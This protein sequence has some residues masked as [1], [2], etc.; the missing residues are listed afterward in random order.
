[1]PIDQRVLYIVE[2]DSACFVGETE[3]RLA[4]GSVRSFA[5][6]VLDFE[7]GVDTK[8]L[9]FDTTNQCFVEVLLGHP[10]VTKMVTELIELITDTG[11]LIKCT[12]DHRFLLEDGKYKEAQHLTEH[13]VIREYQLP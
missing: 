11:E 7:K 4:D 12:V 2:G 9:A 10:R 13:D 8:G 1:V 6:L 3:V 5:E